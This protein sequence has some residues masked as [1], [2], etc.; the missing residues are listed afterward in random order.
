MDENK[1]WISL[2]SLCAAVIITLI[3]VGFGHNYL[4]FKTATEHG[5]CQTAIAGF[6]GPAWEKCK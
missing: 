2:W 6:T 4:I 1:F 3:I 5:L